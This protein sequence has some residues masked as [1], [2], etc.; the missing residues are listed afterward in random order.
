MNENGIEKSVLLPIENPENTSYYVTTDYVIE[1]SKKYPDR[2]IPFCN[3]DPRRANVE[4]VIEEYAEKGCKGF[5]EILTSLYVDDPKMEVIYEVCGEINFPI[6]FDIADYSC[7][8]EIGVPRFE[9]MV[10]K[11]PKTIFIGHGPHFWAEISAD[12]NSIGGYPKG[13]IEKEGAVVKL[14][15]NYPNCYADISAMSGFNAI[16]RDLSFGYEFLE[17]FKD[18]LLFGTNLC[19]YGQKIPHISFIKNAVKEGKISQECFEKIT[20]K[21]AVKILK[22]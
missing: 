7:F 2:F 13:K 20:Y 17:R 12:V 22:L 1:V 19:C 15:S 16:T 6:V 9:K 10:K 14:L 18:K 3:V 21:N 5:G 8:D 4:K 11:F